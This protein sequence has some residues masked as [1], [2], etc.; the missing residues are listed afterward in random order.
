[1]EKQ[2]SSTLNRPTGMVGFT[3]VWAGQIISVLASNMSGFALMI[4]AF[5]KT[6]SATVLG[7]VLAHSLGWMVGNNPGSGMSLQ[8]IFSGVA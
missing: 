3:I 2:H 6:G 1:M 4:W 7:N 5:Q 8:Y